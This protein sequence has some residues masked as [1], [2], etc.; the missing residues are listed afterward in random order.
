[1]SKPF[2]LFSPYDQ[3][4]QLVL[5][6]ICEQERAVI[7]GVGAKLKCVYWIAQQKNWSKKKNRV[8]WEQLAA[9]SGQQAGGVA[10]GMGLAYFG[11][12]IADCGFQNT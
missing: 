2:C 3:E 6:L 11:L 5:I 4:G 7:E 8:R 1:L 10:G 9:G 12:R